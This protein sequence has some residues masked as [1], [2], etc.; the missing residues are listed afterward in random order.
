MYKAKELEYIVIH[1]TATPPN[2]IVT[3]EMI[4]RWHLKE[5]GW[6]KLGY[7]DM[8]H[9]DGSLENLTPFNTDD[10]VQYSEMTWGVKGINR[11]SRHIVYV[12]GVDEDNKPRD[13]RTKAQKQSLLTYV[14]YMILRHPNVKI[15]GHNQF[16]NKAC[17]SFNVVK[18]CVENFIPMKNIHLKTEKLTG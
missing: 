13:T 3:R 18:W 6:S 16:A 12:G 4:E 9:Q 14:R 7:S 15:A 10:D 11:F 8:I 5:R 2:L 17:P 1:C